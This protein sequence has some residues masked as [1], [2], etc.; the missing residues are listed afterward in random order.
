MARNI[1]VVDD[2]ASV[3]YTVRKVL[4]SAGLSVDTASSGDDCIQK[5]K[6]G[7]KGLILMDIVM[8]NKDGW[9]TIREIVDKDLYK[10]SYVGFS[11]CR[12]MIFYDSGFNR[13]KS[14]T[15]SGVFY[16]LPGEMK[17]VHY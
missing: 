12:M 9:D 13:F 17:A 14:S 10:I 6:E 16:I 5:L 15:I 4:E 11:D 8:P 2:D 7:F 3:L 1:L